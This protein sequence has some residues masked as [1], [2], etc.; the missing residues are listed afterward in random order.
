[1]RACFG[2]GQSLTELALSASVI[3]MCVGYLFSIGM[4]AHFNQRMQ[5]HAFKRAMNLAKGAAG[6]YRFATASILYDKAM[7]DTNRW[8]VP[9]RTPVSASFSA[10]HTVDMFAE[11]D[12]TDEELPRVSFDINGKVYTL[13]TADYATKQ[14][15]EFD[16]SNIAAREFIE[17]WDG[18]GVA[19]K[20]VTPEA[21]KEVKADTS[22]DV[23][24]DWIEE[25]IVEVGKDTNN[26]AKPDYIKVMDSNEGDL[27]MTGVNDP[28]WMPPGPELEILR[29]GLLNDS[30]TLVTDQSSITNTQKDNTFTTNTVISNTQATEHLIRINPRLTDYS[31]IGPQIRKNSGS[32]CSY[33]S[34]YA[35]SDSM[36]PDCDCITTS[37]EVDGRVNKLLHIRTVFAN[38][39]DAYKW[40]RE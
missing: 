36:A 14:E 19:W 23:D 5:M 18:N 31:R 38:N 29:N 21:Y 39:K 6:S 26:N 34:D 11:M 8:G 40:M 12:Y 25:T 16:L 2:K 1:M 24:N 3:I 35:C 7:V 17:D 28:N 30:S 37:I 13:T 27:D 15:S 22:W 9:Q 4:R 32:S 20:T 10:V 33:G